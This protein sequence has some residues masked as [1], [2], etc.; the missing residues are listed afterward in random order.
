MKELVVQHVYFISQ[1]P[2]LQRAKEQLNYTNT[3][4]GHLL[5]VGRTDPEVGGGT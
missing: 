4:G 2:M 1:S 5:K 3:S